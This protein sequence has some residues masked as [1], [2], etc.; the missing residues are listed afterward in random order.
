VL[1]AGIPHGEALSI[2]RLAEGVQASP[3]YMAKLLQRL[4]RAGL[5][6]AH[7]GRGGGYSLARSADGVTLWEVACALQDGS[8]AD[9]PTLP[10]CSECSLAAACP[11]K[12]VIGPAGEEMRRRLET[13]TVGGLAKLLEDGARPGSPG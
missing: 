6:T 1:L 2:K 11:L 13:V 4:S 9:V 8:P 5:V 12:A 3:T 10:I 7:R